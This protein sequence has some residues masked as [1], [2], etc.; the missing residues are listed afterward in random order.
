MN[1]LHVPEQYPYGERCPFTGH[2][3]ISLETLIKVP[4][5]IL[6]P[7]FLKGAKKRAPLLFLQRWG[8][9]EADAH[10]QSLT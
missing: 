8:P 10:F 2:F 4:L 6:F 9:M 7:P 1:P 3:C 5:N